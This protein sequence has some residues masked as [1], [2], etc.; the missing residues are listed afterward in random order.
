MIVLRYHSYN[1]YFNDDLEV[2]YDLI[3]EETNLSKRKVYKWI[4]DEKKRIEEAEDHEME[5]KLYL[6]HARKYQDFKSSILREQKMNFVYHFDQK[7]PVRG[8]GLRMVP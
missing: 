8:N 7:Q 3:E 5:Y 1:T 2:D 6:T 4:W